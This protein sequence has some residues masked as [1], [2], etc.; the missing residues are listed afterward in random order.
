M[1]KIER[2]NWNKLNICV[3]KV[4]ETIEIDSQWQKW[5]DWSPE[6]MI[7]SQS[8]GRLKATDR[9][10]FRELQ[11]AGDG[12]MLIIGFL[13]AGC[14]YGIGFLALGVRRARG[15]QRANV[16]EDTVW[17]AA[18]LNKDWIESDS[19]MKAAVKNNGSWREKSS[20]ACWRRSP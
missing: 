13:F 4:K 19:V 3:E 8:Y 9:N 7:S 20:I 15:N 6:S 1:R 12:Q 5:G 2:K 11:G 14:L 18:R 10:R 16:D 17:R